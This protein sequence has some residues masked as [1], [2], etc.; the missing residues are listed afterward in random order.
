MKE[1]MILKFGGT[2][3]AT[4]ITREYVYKKIIEHKEKGGNI[5]AVVSAMGRS[6]DPYA[7]DTI[8]DIIRKTTKNYSMREIDMAFVCGEMISAAVVAS[9]LNEIGYKAMSINGM[10][11]GIYTDG[12]YFDADIKRI[13]KSKMQRHLDEGYILIVTGGQGITEDKEITT[14]GRDGSDTTAIALG[15]ALGAKEV[16]IYKDVKGIMTTDPKIFKNAQLIREISYENCCLLAEEGAK[17]IHPRAVKEAMKNKQMKLYVRS[18]FSEDKGTYI[19][20]IS[21]KDEPSIVGITKKEIGE[22][23]Q[24][25][26][27]TIIGN[28]LKTFK[29]SIFEEIADVKINQYN[30]ND[31]KLEFYLDTKNANLLVE[32]L[33]KMTVQ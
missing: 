32:K 11:A 7:T 9:K 2:S 13:D 33:H 28:R 16:I 29:N 26:K 12:V 20:K 23:P 24:E 21:D 1:L 10:Q 8:L 25:S 15:I 31:N 22:K 5:I 18:T 30:E 27:V 3:L 19:G 6:G 17:V 14:L 4:D